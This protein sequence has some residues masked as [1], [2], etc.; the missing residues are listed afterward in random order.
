M[1]TDTQ[2][3]SSQSVELYKQDFVA[4]TQAQA[5]LLRDRAWE[6][7]DIP[8]LVEEIEALGRRERQELINRLGVL[9]GHLLKYEYQPEK[10]TK[11]W[12]ATIREQRRK[13]T[14]LLAENPSLKPY[15]AEA[16]ES[17]YEDGLDLVVRETPLGYQALPQTCIYSIEQILDHHF[18]PNPAQD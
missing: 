10:Q 15:L 14:A 6:R 11:S 9:I 8:N 5:Q 4:W 18:L 17:A 12:L 3:I 7:L 2:L 13:I 16:C 1:A